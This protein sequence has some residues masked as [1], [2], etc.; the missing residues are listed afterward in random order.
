MDYD[1]RQVKVIEKTA[2]HIRGSGTEHYA[3]IT[4][5]QRFGHLENWSYKGK[6]S[7]PRK[8]QSRFI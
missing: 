5:T 7:E 6:Y 8:G 4:V 2:S 1:S 3:N